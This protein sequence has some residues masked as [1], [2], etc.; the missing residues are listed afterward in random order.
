MPDRLE[1]LAARFGSSFEQ[2]EA[3]SGTAW[4]SIRE[5]GAVAHSDSV[6]P[7]GLHVAFGVADIET[8]SARCGGF[9]ERAP[10]LTALAVPAEGAH[11]TTRINRGVARSFGWHLGELD[12]ALE[13]PSLAAITSAV[14]NKPIAVIRGATALRVA[15]LLT[16]I[17]PWFQG[18]A[19]QL[20]FQSRTLELLAVV[21]QELS[22]S[23]SSQ[24]PDAR[25]IDLQRAHRVRDAIEADLS[26][27]HR[28]EELAGGNP[29]NIHQAT[30]AFRRVFGESIGV[31]LARRRMEEAVRLIGEGA[32]V[33]A[34]ALLVGYTP[35]AFSTAFKRQY[36]FSPSRLF[37]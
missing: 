36:G 24:A 13:D 20:A 21:S 7:Q 37:A 32:S 5:Q 12:A 34:A 14:S 30:R 3:A 4:Q 26:K 31:Y 33:K 35:N 8:R 2:A 9:R 15:S 10:I 16:P 27:S 6:L 25:P 1:A 23:P 19:R 29:S 18:H 17:D 11:F 28:L 22:T